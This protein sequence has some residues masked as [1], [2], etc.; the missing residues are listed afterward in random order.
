MSF[1]SLVATGLSIGFGVQ[2]GSWVCV[3]A[4]G[5]IQGV[6]LAFQRHRKGED[7]E[8]VSMCERCCRP[9]LYCPTEPPGTHDQPHA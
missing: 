4:G 6:I 5:F 2:V 3:Q 1:P 9:C 8:R 7:I